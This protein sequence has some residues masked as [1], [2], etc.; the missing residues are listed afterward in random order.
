[1]KTDRILGIII[2]LTNHDNVSARCLAER[3]H[4]SVR[5]IQRDMISISAMGIP[6]YSEN[7]KNS[8]YSILPTYKIKNSEIRCDEQQMIIKALESLAT[9]YT[10][11][12]LK[13]LIEK[14]N[15]IVQNE[16]GQKVFW[17]FGVTKENSDVQS[18]NQLLENAI[19]LKKYVS[20]EYCNADGKKSSPEVEPL[21]I[22]Y[23]WYAWYLFAYSDDRKQY[24]TY[25][26]ARIQNLKEMDRV[27]GKDHGDVKTLMEVSE[28]D[29][30]RT[31]VQIEVQFANEETALMEEY[32]PDCQIKQISE[33]TKSIFIDVP[34]KERLWKALL[35]SFGNKV[36]VIGPEEYKKELIRTA[37]NFLSN[38][39]I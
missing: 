3:F 24:R 4:V 9:S 39:D 8:G 25:K 31:C 30:Y 26:I 20:F 37:Q 16:G 5:T 1:M 2:Y 23:K 14:Y 15:T 21:A 13:N 34:V 12:T 27:S 6:I 18:K 38:Y 28:Q 32:F 17:D 22:H 35:L 7:G 29:Y 33:N 19:G 10:N 11:D 36:K